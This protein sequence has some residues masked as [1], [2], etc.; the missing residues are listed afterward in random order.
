MARKKEARKQGRG[1]K[2]LAEK[3]R[4]AAVKY[5]GLALGVFAL[6][7]F[8]SV[9]SYM[10]HWTEDAA[11]V[12]GL[13]NSASKAGDAL[14]R[15]LVTDTFGL[16]SLVIV[17]LIAAAAYCLVRRSK[18]AHPV[19]TTA[20]IL[21]ATLLFSSFLA[22]AASLFG[23]DTA[24]GGGLG[25]R[26]GS[27]VSTG[28]NNVFGPLITLCILLLAAVLLLLLS[29]RRFTDWFVSAFEVKPKPVTAEVPPVEKTV[30]DG[31]GEYQKDVEDDLAAPQPD[32][33]YGQYPSGADIY[34]DDTVPEEDAPGDEYSQEDE[35]WQDDSP[36]PE[37]SPVPED[38]F[39]PEDSPV[40]GHDETE[41]GY[42]TDVRQDLPPFDC[43]QG[44]ENYLAPS[45]D[46]LD[47]YAS[48]VKK[49]PQYV[50]DANKE[51]IRRTLLSYKIKI[52]RVDAIVGPTI[53]LYKV[54]L[55]EG[56]KSSSVKNVENDIGLSLAVENVRVVKLADSMGIE[57]P[58]SERSIVPLK[59][60]FDSPEFR[61]SKADL[62]VALGYT[63]NREVK[64][65]DLASAPHLLV[66]GATQQGKSVCLNVIVASLLYAKH[67]SELKLVFI[68]PKKVEFTA[69][70]SLLYHYLAVLPGAANA[71]DEM[72]HAIA[73]GQTEA[74]AILNSL[75]VEM[76]QRYDLLSK[77]GVNKLQDYN[78]KY[79][80]RYLLPTEGHRY[81]PYIVA[82][83][84]E[85][86][87]LLMSGTA[88]EGKKRANAISGFIIRLAQKGRACGIHVIISTQRPSREVVTGLI[89][90]NFPL[91]I[92]FKVA[93][94]TN[95]SIILDTP[96]AEKLTGKGDMLLSGG[97]SIERLQCA[98]ISTDEINGITD[99]VGGQTGA[100][101]HYGTPYYLP[102]PE[103]GDESSSEGGMVD[104]D[105]LDEKFE[106]SARLVVTAQRASVSDLQRRLGMGFAR[107]GKVMDQLEAA[108]IVGPS[109]GPKPREVLVKDFAELQPILDAYLNR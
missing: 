100:H 16:G 31:P 48:A 37:V 54:F 80:K 76:D 6:L 104:I 2:E 90:S 44:L 49:V 45:L 8:I 32:A 59:S 105:N 26:I 73:T 101:A 40:P 71:Q 92:A 83:I 34:G 108:G 22:Y 91:K 21:A 30:S 20:R 55:A 85:Y 50:L 72:N 86:A 87:D 36:V 47:G 41:I 38:S 42:N 24:F 74:E 5:G 99:F 62:P 79:R 23:P 17:A 39:V 67:P 46:L 14:G 13:H 25:G 68:D 18:P 7:S 77:A 60:L 9:V 3:R 89:K 65:I 58:N 19:L 4:A 88:N 12:G 93:N 70:R 81:M 64:V 84:D 10:F 61:D 106:E 95:S 96:G 28:L 69:Y 52:D 75:C 15:F 43:R 35:H 102:E 109:L 103:L 27:A 1:E 97:V 29:S 53:T 63:I 51:R 57:V 11:P 33:E 107:S 56:V 98:Y 78:A 66:A 82:I 94:K